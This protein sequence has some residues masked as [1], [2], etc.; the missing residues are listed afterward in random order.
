MNRRVK[1]FGCVFLC[2]VTAGLFLFENTASSQLV[3]FGFW[4]KGTGIAPGSCV[5][6]PVGAVVAGGAVCAAP[7]Y[8]TTPTDASIPYNWPG[9]I[10]Y[11][12]G[13]N[14]GGHTDW[15]LPAKDQLNSVLYA[16]KSAIGG[17]WA[18]PYWSATEYSSTDAWSQM[19]GSSFYQGH[20]NKVKTGLMVRCIRSY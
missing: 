13:L 12:D 18:T 17:F 4:K 19:F 6:Q 7:G 16:N 20:G 11:C 2:V 5:G 8:M 15:Y 3:P 1:V 14:F 10:S 9:A